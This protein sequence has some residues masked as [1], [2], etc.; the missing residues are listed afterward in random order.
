M[1][2]QN[3]QRSHERKRSKCDL[4]GEMREGKQQVRVIM[5]Q[6][7]PDLCGPAKHPSGWSVRVILT[8]SSASW[9]CR[10]PLRLLWTIRC[11]RGV[12]RGVR[13][14]K[15]RGGG[16][17]SML[18]HDGSRGGRG[19]SLLSAHI[20]LAFDLC[21]QA[22]LSALRHTRPIAQWGWYMTSDVQ[23]HTLTDPLHTPNWSSL[24]NFK[25]N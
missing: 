25:S 14:P 4:V 9:G 5:S 7:P 24:D 19:A 22:E 18:T 12:P 21:L 10:F 8:Q 13:P 3:A 15:P 6:M 1:T 20:C 2:S 23:T 16:Q 17:R 11:L